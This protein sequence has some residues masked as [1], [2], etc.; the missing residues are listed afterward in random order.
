MKSDRQRHEKSWDKCEWESAEHQVG[1]FGVNR[2]QRGRREDRAPDDV[3]Q[4]DDTKYIP[5][6]RSL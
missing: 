1:D 6:K 2:V 3:G 5:D 4:N